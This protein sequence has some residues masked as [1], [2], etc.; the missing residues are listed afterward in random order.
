MV[1]GVRVQTDQIAA[2]TMTDMPLS[3]IERIEVLRG[4]ASALYGES[5]I[6]GV[7]HIQTRQGKGIPATYGA[8]SY[9]S[10]NT[11]NV[12]AG[13][14]GQIED[15]KFDLNAGQSGTKGFS[16]MNPAINSSANPDNDGFRSAYIASKVEKKLNRD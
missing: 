2:L 6:G 14:G 8:F 11:S 7:I 15:V 13:Y 1:D 10:R 9:G 4:N 16:A 5:A 12:Y 3:Q